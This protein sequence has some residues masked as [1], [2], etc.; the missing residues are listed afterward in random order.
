M[1]RRRAF[2]VEHFVEGTAVCP[3]WKD[4]HGLVHVVGLH[5]TTSIRTECGEFIVRS[6]NLNHQIE[7][8]EPC[9]EPATCL[10]CLFPADDF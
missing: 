1:S 9:Y 4:T 2:T 3:G 10:T 6:G 8:F 7:Q 5:T